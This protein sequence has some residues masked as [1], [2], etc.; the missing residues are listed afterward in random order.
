MA[1]QKNRKLGK[2]LGYEQEGSVI[3]LRYE[4]AEA[5]V[6]VLRED[7]IKLFV[8]YESRED[9]SFAVEED[10]HRKVDFTVTYKDVPQARLTVRTDSLS[11]VIGDDFINAIYDAKGCL[12]AKSAD[13]NLVK[14]ARMTEEAEEKMG[15][16]FGSAADPKTMMEEE[17]HENPLEQI[18]RVPAFIVTR[19][20]HA[21]EHFYGLGDKTGFLDKRGYAFDNWNSDIPL[22]HTEQVPAI[23]K[24]IPF[25]IVRRDQ[26]VLGFFYD[27]SY[28]SHIDLGRDDPEIYYYQANGG[29]QVEYILYSPD[30]VGIVSLYTELTGRQS[31]P[32]LWTLGYQQS[33]WGY[34]SARKFLE[35]ADQM[36]RQRIPCDA[37]HFDIDYMDGYRVFTWNQEYYGRRPQDLLDDLHRKGFHA[38]PIIDPGVKKDPGYA[39]YDEGLNRDYF[40]KDTEGQVYVN[41]VWPGEAV[42]PDFGRREVREW[43]AGKEKILADWGFDATWNDMNEP[44]SFRGELPD[45]VCFHQED[46]PASHAKIHN[47]YGCL[48]SK[49]ANQGLR[50]ANGKRPFVITR[51]T[52]AGGQKYSTVWTGDNQSIWAHLQM[53]IPQLCNLGLSGFSLAGT[54]I[55]GFIGD[56]NA[57]LM[58][59]WIEAA[60]F[61]PLFRNHSAMYGLFQEPWQFGDEVTDIYRKF[62]ELRYRLLPYIYD[63]C[64]MTEFTGLPVMR[65]LVLHYPNDPNVL[66][67]NDQFLAGEDLMAAPILEQGKTRRLVYFPQ[68]T[69][70]DYFTGTP[71]EGGRYHVIE[72]NL[73]QLPLFARAGAIIPNWEVMQYVGEREYDTLILKVFPGRGQYRHYRD[74]GEDFDYRQG[75]VDIYEFS[76]KN[77]RLSGR[78]TVNGYGCSYAHIRVE[79]PLGGNSYSLK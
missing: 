12:L 67:I 51:A 79:E 21:D 16:I 11:L 31:L 64:R 69:W 4:E 62:V 14:P 56:A 33:R 41:A 3:R 18:N 75:K 2:L 60:V 1:E 61:S 66:E 27:N 73:D 17:G 59:R 35:I 19:E 36:R 26:G 78:Q 57:E 22:A 76:Q 39:V 72:A 45:D 10:L 29:N 40:A 71:Y 52:Y 38:V 32:Q 25:L 7:L 46:Q 65:P 23:Y 24:S 9:H 37:L 74:N 70:Y 43:W 30:M 15:K 44:A 54:D 6:D 53:M 8:A 55:G 77:G 58:V 50:E 47:V 48:M 5:S 63:L 68:G 28:R 49:A 13:K 34:D 20:M 42:F